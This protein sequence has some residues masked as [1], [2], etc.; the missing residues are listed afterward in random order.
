MTTA[1]GKKGEKYRCNHCNSALFELATDL[2]PNMLL[3]SKLFSFIKGQQTNFK[4]GSVV[5]CQL[6]GEPWFKDGFIR[7][8]MVQETWN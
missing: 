4:P 1:L 8:K 2:L 5:I 6:C 7:A 3:T